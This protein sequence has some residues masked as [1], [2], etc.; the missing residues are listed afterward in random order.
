M[1]LEASCVSLLRS[2][3]ARSD[4]FSFWC[5]GNHMHLLIIH[6][7]SNSKL[8]R[9]EAASNPGVHTVWIWMPI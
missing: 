6:Y 4:I 9:E 5:C 1:G 7:I 8:K 2:L 3:L